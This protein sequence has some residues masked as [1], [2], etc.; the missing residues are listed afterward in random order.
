[1]KPVDFYKIVADFVKEDKRWR[2]LKVDD[3][4]YEE[5]ARGFENDYHKAIITEI[6]I[7][8]RVIV[9]DDI[10]VDPPVEKKYH[11]FL[12]QEEFNKL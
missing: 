1:M 8:E 7:D 2:A 5:I 9:V 10:S 3:I 6:N 12:T 4:V 11:H